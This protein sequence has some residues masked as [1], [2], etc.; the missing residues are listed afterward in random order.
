MQAEKLGSGSEFNVSIMSACIHLRAI[1]KNLKRVPGEISD[2]AAG[3]KSNSS[4]Q[5]KG[6][7]IVL[8]LFQHAWCQKW[9]SLCKSANKCLDAEHLWSRIHKCLKRGRFFPLERLHQEIQLADSLT[10]FCRLIIIPP[11][12]LLAKLYVSDPLALFGFQRLF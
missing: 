5:R 1:N 3:W 6:L 9:N 7:C 11:P 8:A 12:F 4:G 10:R 2:A